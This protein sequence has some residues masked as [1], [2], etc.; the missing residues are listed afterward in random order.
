MEEGKKERQDGC[1]RHAGIRERTERKVFAYIREQ[2]MIDPG[3]KIAAGVSG[4]ADSL[5]MLYLLLEYA[6]QVPLTVAVV[7]INHGLRA[8][9]AEEAR[10]VEELCRQADVPF[11]LTCA[12]VAAVSRQEKCSAEDAGRRVRYR[13]FCRAAE[14]MG[15]GK[16]A[17]AHNSNDN[18]E[19]ML[20]HLFRG[21]G[22]RGLCGISPV[23]SEKGS[24]IIR[25]ILCLERSEAEEY[26]RER[27]IV[28]CTDSTNDED[29]YSRNRIRHHILPCAERELFNGAIGHMARTAE[30]LAETEAYLE[31]QTLEALSLCLREAPSP[32]ASAGERSPEFPEKAGAGSAGEAPSPEDSVRERTGGGR[33]VIDIKTFTAFHMVLRKRMLHELMKR[34]SPSGKDIHQVHV[35]DTLELFDREG[36]GGVSLPFGIRARKQYGFVI[37]E[38]SGAEREPVLAAEA[39]CGGGTVPG[40]EEISAEPFVYNLGKLG[41]LEFTVFSAKKNQ[42]ILQ[43]RYTKWFDCDKIE[44]SLVIRFRNTGDYFTIAD[45]RGGMV[46][47][48][49]KDYMITEKIPAPHRDKI[50]VLAM[51]KHVL[52][53][54]GRR[55]SEYFKVGRNTKHILQ[56]RLM[57]EERTEEK[58]VGTH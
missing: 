49:L 58:N 52:W 8:E 18:A 55:I 34:L 53:L 56:V 24:K 40:W 23:R 38:V 17:V 43:N 50:P 45:G 11:Y 57:E 27:G 3:D 28:W 39:E 20:F 2:G 33:Y 16:I 13:A 1:G 51:G 19:T 22:L 41:K 7:H 44:E 26:L 4:G 54:V 37:L 5:C 30:M 6:A 29:D 10:Y 36:N 32:G 21:S 31:E 12:D 14:D 25:P 15:G 35:K 47:K 48:S 9:A 42:E 46:H